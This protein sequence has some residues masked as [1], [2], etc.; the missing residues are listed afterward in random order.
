MKQIQLYVEGQRLDMFN[1]ESVS[2]TDTLKNVKDVN[3]LFTEYSQTFKV[4]AS[5]INNKVF[6]HYYNSDIANGYDARIRVQAEIE[7]NN[8]SFKKG[9]I[10]LEGV[11]LKNNNPNSYKI[12]FFGSTVSLKSLLG[13]DLL[14]D[15]DWLNNL[16]TDDQG[17]VLTFSATTMKKYLTTSVDRTIAGITYSNPL[18]V[19]LM[20]RQQRLYYD[21][22]KN[23][24]D[25]SNLYYGSGLGQHVQGVKWNDLKPAIKMPFII[26][27]IEEK[28]NI[29]NGY[30]QDLKFSDDFFNT[31]N[32][33][34]DDLYMWLHRTQDQM[35]NP[36]PVEIGD[37]LVSD[38]SPAS[39]DAGVSI[40]SGGEVVEFKLGNNVSSYFSLSFNVAVASGYTNIS[41][42]YNIYADGYLVKSSG[43]LVGSSL[44]VTL[45]TNSQSSAYENKD[46]TVEFS[47]TEYME[48]TYAY[49]S[50]NGDWDYQTNQTHQVYGNPTAVSE[51]FQIFPTQQVPKMKVLDFLTNVFKMFNLVAYIED[52]ITV[53][54]TLDSFY[55]EGRGGIDNTEI[56]YD[57]T[58]YIDVT[59]SQSNSALPFR[60]IIFTYQGL[61]TFLAENHNQLFNKNWGEEEYSTNDSTIFSGGIFKYEIAFEHLKFERLYNIATEVETGIQWGYHVSDT[62]DPYVGKPALLYMNLKTVPA[63]EDGEISFVNEVDYLTN[64]AE[65]HEPISTYY[66]PSNS[67]MNV[68]AFEDQPSLNFYPEFDEWEGTEKNGNTLFNNYHRQYMSSIFNKSNRLT[69]V[70]AYLPMKILLNYSLADRFYISGKSYKINSIETNLQTGKSDMELLNDIYIAEVDDVAPSNPTNL[71]SPSQGQ[72]TIDITWTASTGN[73]TGYIVELDQGSTLITIGNV[74]SYT[75]TNLTGFTTYK[76]ALKAFNS[77]G[78]ESGLSNI[79]NIQT[80]Q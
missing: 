61:A 67:D 19:P 8:L 17:D 31:S 20:T 6:R 40:K 43:T 47:F 49:Y 54:K 27:A 53:V 60:E 46:L 3:K 73:V 71:S 42:S 64:V 14:S 35:E 70:S 48:I 76:I 78:T 24:A 63:L 23:I 12:T 9:Y 68:T 4:P 36:T 28:Y 13:E 55:N 62:K 25:D 11:D 41:Y 30:F 58:S 56:G 50:L 21:S 18:Q 74:T 80:T 2:V 79:I 7:L 10:K 57:I 32:K 22:N 77:F 15:L 51:G 52:G 5:K 33:A 1:D 37:V 72:T 34:W 65:D 59:S 44:N 29:A 66:A 75:I 45:F 16:A 39:I 69:K 38:W 26:K